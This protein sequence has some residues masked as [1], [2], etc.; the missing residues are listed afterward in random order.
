MF[1]VTNLNVGIWGPGHRPL[2]YADLKFDFDFNIVS[3]GK[4][5]F[6]WVNDF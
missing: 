5:I 1:A 6:S 3:G 2:S 4:G